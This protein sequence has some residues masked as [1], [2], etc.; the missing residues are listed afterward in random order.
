MIHDLIE[1]YHAGALTAHHLAV[2]CL[3][4]LDP[5][6]PEV[7]LAHLPDDVLVAVQEFA[8]RYDPDAMK[9]N[10]GVIPAKDQVIAAAKW[11][12]EKKANVA[13]SE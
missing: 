11:I 6:E 5:A 12:Q 7:V 9:T 8:D 10:Y 13:P 1:K 2:E 3:Q 4:M